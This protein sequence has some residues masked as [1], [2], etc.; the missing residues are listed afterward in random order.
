MMYAE[1][2]LASFLVKNMKKPWLEEL[3]EYEKL[4]KKGK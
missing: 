3:E 2:I 4:E 1:A